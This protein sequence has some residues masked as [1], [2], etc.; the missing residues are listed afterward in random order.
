MQGTDR[1]GPGARLAECT[2][3]MQSSEPLYFGSHSARLHWF[4]MMVGEVAGQ[5]FRCT[6]INAVPVPS[7][8]WSKP[9]I[10]FSHCLLGTQNADGPRFFGKHTVELCYHCLFWPPVSSIANKFVPAMLGDVEVND[11]VCCVD[12]SIGTSGDGDCYWKSKNGRQSGFYG[13]LHGR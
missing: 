3:I 9:C 7:A 5:W 13:F 6:N 1:G 8:Q 10:E 11:L 12:S 4:A 2:E